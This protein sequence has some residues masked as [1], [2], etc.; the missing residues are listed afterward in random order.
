MSFSPYVHFKG[1]CAE[2]MTFYAK[3]F[4]ATDLYLM[5]YCEVPETQMPDSDLVIHGHLSIDGSSL[6][7]SDFPPT[8]AGDDQKA[9]SIATNVK[10]VERGQALFDQLVEGGEV[11]NP[12]GPSFFSPGFGMVKDRFGTHWLIIT[13][14]AE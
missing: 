9:V 10:T 8:M 12:F 5:R 1:N 11:I 14:P 3:V 7:A 4:G 6:M 13:Q 2:A